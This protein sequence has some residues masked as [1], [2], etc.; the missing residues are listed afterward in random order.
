[1]TMDRIKKAGK[2]LGFDAQKG[3]LYSVFTGIDNK[4]YLEYVIVAVD[5]GDIN[6]LIDFTA[7]KPERTI[8]VNPTLAES[9]INIAI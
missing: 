7:P 5:N 6:Y 8:E 1:M 4:G 3:Y 9:I 2:Y